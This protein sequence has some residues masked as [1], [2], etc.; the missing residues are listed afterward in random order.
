MLKLGSDSFPDFGTKHKGKGCIGLEQIIAAAS[1]QK[2]TLR[3]FDDGSVPHT[4]H[5]VKNRYHQRFYELVGSVYFSPDDRNSSEMW[6]RMAHV[7][8]FLTGSDDRTPL[9]NFK[10]LRARYL[11]RF[12]R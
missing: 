3:Q 10:A 5:S 4:L 11:S 12:Y 9:S 1:R 2:E 8:Q 6:L 7:D